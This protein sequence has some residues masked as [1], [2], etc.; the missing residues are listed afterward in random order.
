ME[1]EEGSL[2][3]DGPIDPPTHLNPALV[4]VLCVP[5]PDDGV[6]ASSAEDLIGGIKVEGVDPGTIVLLLNITDHEGNGLLL[7]CT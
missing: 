1:G 4:R 6:P 2:T 5:Q 7:A 3:P